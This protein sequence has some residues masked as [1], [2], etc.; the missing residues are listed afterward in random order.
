MKAIVIDK[1]GGPDVL[2]IA[3]LEKPVPDEKH[4]LIKVKAIGINPV[5][6]KVRAGGHKISN[7]IKFPA[8]L[9]WDISGMIESCGSKVKEFKSGDEVFGNLGFPGLSGGYAEYVLANQNEIVVKPS[10]I[11]FEEA[12]ALPVVGL[13][14]WQ[15]IHD[16]L[17]LKYGQ[18]VLIQA[19]SGG[20]G[21]IAVQLAKLAGAKVFGTASAKNK[22][23]VESLGVDRFIDYTSEDFT[24]IANNLDAAIDAMGGEVLYRSIQCVRPG[25]R[26]VCLP[27][28]TKDDPKA[29]ELAK[30]CGVTLMWPMMYKDNNHLTLLAKLIEDKKLKIEVRYIFPFEKMADAH[31]Q[32]ET[33]RTVG[34]VVVNVS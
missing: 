24:K 30:K 14:A 18:S 25:G 12:A 3:D 8:I 20:V 13:T 23:F 17:K 21:H 15:A 28:S 19:S 2:K 11:S 32:I 22:T 6:T 27:S 33:H 29:I 1:F 9:G 5:D 10:G 4:I 31:R 34:K 26:V 7:N 16:H